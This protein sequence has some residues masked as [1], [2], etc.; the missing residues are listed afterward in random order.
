MCHVMNIS[1]IA[2]EEDFRFTTD[3]ENEQQPDQQQPIKSRVLSLYDT[4]ISCSTVVV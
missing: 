3:D 1:C 2:D 4:S